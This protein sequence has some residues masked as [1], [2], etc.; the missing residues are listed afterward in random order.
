MDLHFKSTPK[1]LQHT[2]DESNESTLHESQFA[3]TVRKKVNA[4]FKEMGISPKGNLKLKVKSV[5]MLSFYFA[6]F[7]ILLAVK[8]NVWIALSLVILMGIGIAGIGMG[9]MHD[10]LHGSYSKREWLNKLMGCTLYLLGGHVFNWRMQHNVM[11][12]TYTNIEGSDED[13]MSRGIIRFSE[14]APLRKIHRYQYIH[15]FFFYGLMTLIK[16]IKDFVQLA[17]YNKSGMTKK[18]NASPVIEYQ[19][20]IVFKIIYLFIIIGLPILLTPFSWWQVI[21]G[22]LIMHWVAGSI[23]SIVFQMANIVEGAEQPVP[24][25]LGVINHDWAVHEM[26]T[27]AN[28]A[29]NNRLLTWYAGGLNYQIEHHLFPYIS[30]VHYRKIAP[31]VEQTAREFGLPYNLK[32]TFIKAFASHVKRLKELGVQP[33]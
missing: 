10:A 15:A 31:I 11:H 19:K 9:V 25:A 13:I 27:T 12:H 3:S 24:D 28:F 33:A 23:L 17:E 7:V 4:Y 21:L 5:T 29:P 30:H 14:N 8:M 18:Y 32:P 16:L 6:P 1:P 2:N 22:F 20:L 26:R